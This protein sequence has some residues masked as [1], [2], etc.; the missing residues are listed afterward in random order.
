MAVHYDTD[1]GAA[2]PASSG[3]TVRAIRPDDA[4]SL[5]AFHLLLSNETI[6]NRYFSAH[7]ELTDAEAQRL[8]ALPV[9]DEAAFVA[10]EGDGIVAVGRFIRL[11]GT[12]A[13]EVAFV[14]ADRWQHHGI[15]TELLWLLARR[16]WS[17][18]IRRFI[19]DTLVDNHAML[20][21][22]MHTPAAVTVESTSRD[23]SVIH[24]VMRVSEPSD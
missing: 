18:G 24:L 8:T 6:R 16:G 5:K 14:V 19:A 13:A 9:G 11:G 1:A 4:A 17:D 23:G 10:T 3:L 21:V 2:A 22:F 15:G 20:A 12:D 7:R